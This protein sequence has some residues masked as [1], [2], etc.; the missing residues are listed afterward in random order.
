MS[1]WISN[2]INKKLA[3]KINN[4]EEYELNDYLTYN[5]LNVIVQALLDLVEE[6]EITNRCLFMVQNEAV[7]N[8]I[9]S[10][11]GLNATLINST[12]DCDGVK[13]IFNCRELPLYL[14]VLP[15]DD[16]ADWLNFTITYDEVNKTIQL[17]ISETTALQLSD[18]NNNRI[19]S[20]TL[21]FYL[22]SDKTNLFSTLDGQVT[23][24]MESEESS[25]D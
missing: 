13:I 12:S 6:D 16:S 24:L 5:D 10:S 1:T 2:E 15:K 22:D 9:I 14:E 3:Q 19:F 23:Y 11:D 7:R 20:Y 25:G 21:K 8:R 18:T 4:N 17:R